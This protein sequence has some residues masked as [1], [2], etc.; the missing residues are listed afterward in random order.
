MPSEDS[1]RQ[2]LILWLELL[3]SGR[4]PDLAI[5]GA[6]RCVDGIMQRSSPTLGH[7]ALEADLCGVAMAHL[8]A[9]GSAADWMVS[10][11]SPRM[12][13]YVCESAYARRMAWHNNFMPH[14]LLS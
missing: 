4:L 1:P 11:N 6:W 9:I 8:R 12:C 13:V 3:Q 2:M 5:G 14:R 10:L 7:V